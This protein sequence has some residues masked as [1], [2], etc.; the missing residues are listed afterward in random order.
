[1]TF[2][3]EVMQIEERENYFKVITAVETGYNVDVYTLRVSFDI[4][5][6]NLSVRHKVLFTGQYRKRD[7][8]E[9]FRLES[10]KQINFLS[11][12]KCGYPLTSYVC[13]IKHDQEAQRFDGKWKIVHKMVTQGVVKLF[14]LQGTF[15]FAAVSKPS[16]WVHSKFLMLE[17]NDFV[18]LE[19]WRYQ[20]KTSIKFIEKVEED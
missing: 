10:I 18:L 7:G 19:G 8:I 17:E 9:Q 2:L 12:L 1:M 14:F 3:G 5:P 6:S 13:F 15:C 11:C 20:R 16:M 4:I